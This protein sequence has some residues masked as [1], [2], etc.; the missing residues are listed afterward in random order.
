MEWRKYTSKNL[1]QGAYSTT[2]IENRNLALGELTN[3]PKLNCL[4]IWGAAECLRDSLTS[5]NIAC[6]EEGNHGAWLIFEDGSDIKAQEG[7]A[8][9]RFNVVATIEERGIDFD[10]VTGIGH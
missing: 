3:I 9:I 1:S 10:G 6:V 7:A 8:E 4:R 5:L 2:G